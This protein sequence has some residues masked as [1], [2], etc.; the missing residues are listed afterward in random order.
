LVIDTAAKLEAQGESITPI[1]LV[2]E[3]KLKDMIEKY[4]IQL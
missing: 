4:E 3:N 1:L 2:D